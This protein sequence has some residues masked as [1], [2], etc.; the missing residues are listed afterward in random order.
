MASGWHLVAFPLI[1]PWR[2]EF[3]TLPLYFPDLKVGVIPGW[4]P[5]LPYRGMPLPPEAEPHPTELKHYKPGDLRQWQAFRDFQQEQGEEGDLLREIRHYGEDA[6]PEAGLAA[7]VWSLAWQLEK[8][9]ADQDVQMLLVDKGQDWLK[10][11]LR[12]EPWEET[13]SFGVV[14]GVGEMVDPELAKLRY[15]LWLRV[16]APQLEE[17]WVPLLLGRTSRSLFLTLKGWPQWTG[18][19][20]AQVP[21]PGL[22][23]GSEWLKVVGAA[24]APAWQPQFQSLL[25]AVLAAAVDKGDLEEAA[26]KLR[27]FMEDEVV[28]SWPF[29]AV[30]NWDLEIW[31][32]DHSPPEEGPILCWAG[33]GS[34]I[35]PG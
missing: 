22:Q 32:P 11:I 31:A 18:L 27:Q 35:L 7:D 25:A 8:M 14:P 26:Q 12:P 10:D 1:L 16:M 5:Q 20:K 2:E 28:S 29:P 9:Q 17:P 34:G 4:P 19:V 24:G 3:W 15:Q 6:A 23:S 13:S 30:R 33:A 21:L